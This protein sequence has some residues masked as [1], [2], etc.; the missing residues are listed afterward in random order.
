MYDIN[1]NQVVLSMLKPIERNA[2]DQPPAGDRYSGPL[3][4]ML[5]DRIWKSG[6]PQHLPTLL[7]DL[8]ANPD[9]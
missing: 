2:L 1:I 3:A 7:P 6:V 5:S 9:A 8:L 4:T